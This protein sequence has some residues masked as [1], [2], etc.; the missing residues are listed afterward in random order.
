MKTVQILKFTPGGFFPPNNI[1][2]VVFKKT[3]TFLEVLGYIETG[4]RLSACQSIVEDIGI[5]TKG[6][7]WCWPCHLNVI[8][9]SNI[10]EYVLY[11]H[12]Y[13]NSEVCMFSI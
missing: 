5:K 4:I 11:G 2:S 9:S 8:C 13:M 10:F 1:I 12:C 6:W 7:E 3:I